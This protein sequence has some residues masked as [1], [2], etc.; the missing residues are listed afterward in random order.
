MTCA[1]GIVAGLLIAGHP[2]AIWTGALSA[3]LAELAGM[4]SGQLQSAPEDGVLAAVVCGIASLL[5]AVL[6]AAPY[7]FLAGLP[8]LI[9]AVAVVC[10]LCAVVAVVRPQSGPKAW[11]LSYGVTAAACGLCVLGA[12]V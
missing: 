3:G 9:A 5:G 4:F 2:G 8:A 1:A 7:I 12:L 6:P 11:L 10:L